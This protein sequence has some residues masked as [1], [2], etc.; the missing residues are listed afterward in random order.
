MSTPIDLTGYAF[1]LDPSRHVLIQHADHRWLC[2]RDALLEAL[3][4]HAWSI[5]GDKHL[6]DA[7]A[8]MPAFSREDLDIDGLVMRARATQIPDGSTAAGPNDTPLPKLFRRPEAEPGVGGCVWELESVPDSSHPHILDAVLHVN[9]VSQFEDDETGSPPSLEHTVGQGASGVFT[10]LA[11][12]A[13]MALGTA[14]QHVIQAR[15]NADDADLD[16]CE[17]VAS[18]QTFTFGPLTHVCGVTVA[19]TDTDQ[20]VFTFVNRIADQAQRYI[21][22]DDEWLDLRTG[23]KLPDIPDTS[24]EQEQPK[25]SDGYAGSF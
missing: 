10:G 20:P 4:T 1:P 15:Q 17:W 5:F 19:D 12:A 21:R 23:F 3:D 16:G 6:P 14:R 18:I 8:W 13:A 9:G 2:G 11:T 22:D 24:L 7:P 25:R